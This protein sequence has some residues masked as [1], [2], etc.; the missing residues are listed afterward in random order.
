VWG[1]NAESEPRRPS[2]YARSFYNHFQS[3]D[4]L[5][6]AAV[7]DALDTFGACSTSSRIYR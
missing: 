7:K 1:P 2:R 3:K 4:E 5:F 6:H